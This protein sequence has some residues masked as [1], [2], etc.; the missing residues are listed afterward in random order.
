MSA[1]GIANA[2]VSRIGTSACSIWTVGITQDLARR[3]SE[4]L[5]DK[6]NVT[7]WTA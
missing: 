2:I 4:H 5:N 1:Q 3:K 7:H 6:K